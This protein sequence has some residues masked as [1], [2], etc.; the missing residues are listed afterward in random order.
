V[1]NSRAVRSLTGVS[2]GLRPFWKPVDLFTYWKTGERACNVHYVRVRRRLHTQYRH[3]SARDVRML[4]PA[5]S[6]HTPCFICA[7]TDWIILRTGGLEKLR[8]R[9]THEKLSVTYGTVSFITLLTRARRSEQ[10]GLHGVISQKAEN[11]IHS[12]VPLLFVNIVIQFSFMFFE[13]GG[14]RSTYFENEINP[15]NVS[16]VLHIDILN[17]LKKY[18]F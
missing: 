11:F 14:P 13:K 4:R 9:Q 15:I 3:R 12:H 2:R 1:W 16:L 17:R 18:R 8:V 6:K 7:K 5:A 10:T